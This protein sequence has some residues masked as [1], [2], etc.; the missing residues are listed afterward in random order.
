MRADQI[1]IEPV[2]TE[3]TNKLRELGKKKYTFKV[4]RDANKIEI[5]QA[6]FEL[7]KVRPISCN[8]IN[9]KS[10]PKMTRT[11]SSQGAGRTTPWKKAI[12]TLKAGEKIDTFESV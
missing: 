8:V 12:V 11:K 4:A 10:K 9:V 1:I 6:V 5:M 3:K 2:L 7:F